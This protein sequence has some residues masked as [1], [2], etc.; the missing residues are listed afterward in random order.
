MYI[1]LAYIEELVS[2]VEKLRKQYP[3]YEKAKELHSAVT[4]DNPPP[5]SSSHPQVPKTD[6]ITQHRSRFSTAR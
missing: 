4:Q 5:I 2:E 3:S 6:L 1:H